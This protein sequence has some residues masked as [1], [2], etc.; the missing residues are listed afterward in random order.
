MSKISVWLWTA[1]G[2]RRVV[3]AWGVAL[4]GLLGV[5]WA[6]AED[7]TLIAGQPVAVL[8]SEEIQGEVTV[9]Q[10]FVAPYP[11]LTRIAV[12]MQPFDRVNTHEVIFHLKSGREA[13]QDIVTIRF[14]PH[15]L[16]SKT[17]YDFSFP[18]IEDSAGVAYYFYLES[19]SSTPGNAIA[20]MGQEGDPY[21]EGVAYVRGEAVPGDMTFRTY[22]QASPGR[23]IDF[24]LTR[25]TANKPGVWGNRYFYAGLIVV[26]LVGTFVLLRQLAKNSERL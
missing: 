2:G 7:L 13:E 18:P 12:M 20:V 11:G 15:N 4:L 1:L 17:W 10:T 22:Y 19:P 6:T 5:G 26:Y 25:F 8:S 24:L 3:I 16:K 14:I 21:P 9:G 23:R